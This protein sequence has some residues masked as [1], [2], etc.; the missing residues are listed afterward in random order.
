MKVIE[1]TIQ[2]PRAGVAPLRPC[3]FCGAEAA[4]EP[5]PWLD[6]S[7]RIVCGNE[8]CGVRPRTETLLACYADEL[9][10]AWN[11]RP[12]PPREPS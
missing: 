10:A 6:E 3:P 11:A 5:D 7:L 2:L 12:A 8:A 9:C 1:R 4:L